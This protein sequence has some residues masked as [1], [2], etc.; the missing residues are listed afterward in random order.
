MWTNHTAGSSPS[1]G[2]VA[3]GSR[4]NVVLRAVRRGVVTL[5]PDPAPVIGA[6]S[7]ARPLMS[8]NP[9]PSL[10]PPRRT[11]VRL[12][13][14]P[15]SLAFT[16]AHGAFKPPL[17][18]ARRNVG[19][20][21]RASVFVQG[22][23]GGQR[24]HPRQASGQVRAHTSIRHPSPALLLPVVPSTRSSTGGCDVCFG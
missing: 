11:R 22:R 13:R 9:H 16:S 7:L 5:D 10:R 17:V 12:R 4:L 21:Q 1:W 19:V 20:L 6:S 14:W 24:I 2:G 23:E 18:D 15:D 3:R 8:P